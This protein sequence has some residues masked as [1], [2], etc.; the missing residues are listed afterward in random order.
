MY[1]NIFLGADMQDWLWHL[2]TAQL[3]AITVSSLLGIYPTGV[4]TSSLM[5]ARLTL[6]GQSCLLSDPGALWPRA[7]LSV[8]LPQL[9]R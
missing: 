9:C 1:C 6:R 4:I 2:K 5:E 8:D 7:T 3:M